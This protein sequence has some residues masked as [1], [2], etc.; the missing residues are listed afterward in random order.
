MRTYLRFRLGPLVSYQRLGRTQAQ[1]RAAAKARAARKS[2]RAGQ[3]S[4]REYNGQTDTVRGT[5]VGFE[6]GKILVQAVGTYGFRILKV[7]ADL[8]FA[9]SQLVDVTYRRGRKEYLSDRF[10]THPDNR[11]AGYEWQ[12]F[13]VP[14]ATVKLVGWEPPEAPQWEPPWAPQ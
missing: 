8:Q 10:H 2:A 4:A 6:D 12:W 1:N 7:Q 11:L 3:R 5:V 14:G 9:E 13:E